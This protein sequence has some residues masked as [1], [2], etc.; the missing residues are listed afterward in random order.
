MSK[1][2]RSL[3]NVVCSLFA[4]IITIA[5]GLVIPRITMVGYGSAV[6]GLLNSVNQ[7]IIYLA[8]FEAGIQAVAM[9]SLYK[10][11]SIND[12]N[13]IN[14]ILS[15]VHINYRRTGIFYLLALLLLSAV[16]PFI[17]AD[18][19]IGYLTV[20]FVVLF[21]GLPNVVLFL[22]Q[23]KYRILL[24]AEG[25]NY[26]LTNLTL[27]TTVVTSVVKILLLTMGYNVV[28]VV[29]ATFIISLVQA[30]FIV[31]YFKVKYKWINIKAE[32]DFSALEQKNS[33]LIHQIAGLVFQNTDVLILTVFCDLRVVSVYS[34]Y[35]LIVAHLNNVM[36]I[37]FNSITFVLGQ[38]YN[39]DKKR[40]LKLIDAT[41]VFYAALT[42]SVYSV[43][44]ALMYP[45]MEL[46]TAGVQDIK[47]ADMLLV[48]LFAAVELLTFARTPMLNTINYA[49]HFKNT[50]PQTIIETVINLVVSL[51]SVYFLGIAGVLLGT[52]A[53][54][55]YRTID[56]IIYSNKKLLERKPYKTFSVY[57]VNIILLLAFQIVYNL[58]NVR[59]DS[60]TDFILVGFVSAVTSI[61][62]HFSVSVLIYNNE[63]KLLVGFVKSKLSKKQ[64]DKNVSI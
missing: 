51:S 4:Q 41:E 37:P 55:L 63:R 59:I 31:S 36:N 64:E 42:F 29:F 32:P 18:S 60:Y 8:L 28:M 48:V 9:Q 11:V 52:I 46:Y 30:I 20:F 13:N 62:L 56:I 12:H 26:I 54:L 15:A 49:G 17:V 39:T 34:M 1:T 14:R 3:V 6:N 57:I 25:K 35:K 58:F 38:S 40:F 47:Y 53:A 21:S 2:K 43:F 23:G 50:L 45:F 10:P 61:M 19:G 5:L 33:A 7:I 24:Q 22:F 27:T 44:V 16:Y